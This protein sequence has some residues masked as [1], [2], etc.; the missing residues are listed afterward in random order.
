MKKIIKI[1]LIVL[2]ALAA[3]LCYGFWETG[4]LRA[5]SYLAQS[6]DLPKQLSGLKIVFASDFHCGV[7]FG[8]DRAKKTVEKINGLDPDI[9]ILGG[10]YIDED[11]NYIGECFPEFS[12]LKAKRGIYAVLGNHDYRNGMAEKIREA[13]AGSNLILLENSGVWID[14]QCSSSQSG[15]LRIGGV[16]DL[17]RSNPNID[18]ALDGVR[19]K[20]FAVLVSHNPFLGGITGKKIDLALA[21]HTHG[22]QATLFGK[23]SVLNFLHQSKNIFFG[24]RI[25]DGTKFIISRGVGTTYLPVRFFSPAEINLITLER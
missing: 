19:E 1:L 4:K 24:Q 16:A 10:D 8:K 5:V 20:D 6:N 12:L 25:I 17:L 23:W 21:G 13:M 11:Q 3:V 14:F 22:G 9:I 18:N 15:R 2:A 7:F